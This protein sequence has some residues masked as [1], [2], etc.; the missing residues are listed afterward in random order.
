MKEYEQLYD[1]MTL[2]KVLACLLVQGLAAS[3][4]FI[5]QLVVSPANCSKTSYFRPVHFD[6]GGPRV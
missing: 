3:W 1:S 6:V 4:M 2:N 5:H